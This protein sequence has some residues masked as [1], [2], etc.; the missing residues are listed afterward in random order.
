MT[1]WEPEEENFAEFTFRLKKLLSG[2]HSGIF[3]WLVSL[4]SLLYI[5][6]K[7]PGVSQIHRIATFCKPGADLREHL[8]GFFFPSLILKKAAQTY[9]GS[10]FKRFRL[11]NSR[12]F[13]GLT[14]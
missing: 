11:P 4:T 14:E 8:Q 13:D 5:G 9:H 3:K 1:W 10:E 6:K 7:R 2:A 12:A